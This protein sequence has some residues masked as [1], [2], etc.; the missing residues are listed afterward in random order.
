MAEVLSPDGREQEQW[1]LRFVECDGPGW[2]LRGLVSGPSADADLLVEELRQVF[3]GSV[4][5]LDA[6]PPRNDEG[7]ILQWPPRSGWDEAE[8]PLAD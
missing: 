8:V 4:I 7:V 2:L 5:D 1:P 3:I 6:A